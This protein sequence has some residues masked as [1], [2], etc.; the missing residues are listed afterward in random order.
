MKA[1]HPL[2]IAE[3]AAAAA[4][5]AAFLAR[6]AIDFCGSPEWSAAQKV[7][8]EKC[9]V[10]DLATQA[11]YD[12]GVEHAPYWWSRPGIYDSVK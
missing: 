12:A 1:A 6:D 5:Q 11:L 7:A 8:T 3:R 9:R 4:V 10:W 2:K